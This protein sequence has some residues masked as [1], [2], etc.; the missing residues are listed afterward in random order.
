MATGTLHPVLNQIRR[1]VLGRDGAGQ[2][3]GQLLES[4]ISHRDEAA[5]EVLVH[6]H[7]PM[8]LGVCRR[9]LRHHHDAEDAFQ[10][11]FLVLVRKAAWIVPRDMVANWL[12]GVACRTALKARA[13][14]ARRRAHEKQVMEMPEAEAVEPDECWRDLHPLLDQ[15]LS[16]LPD[17]YRL[18]VVL[19]HL[20]GKTGREA[21]RLLGWPEG[22]V[23][24]R[25]ARARALLARRLA[26][27]GLTASA[28][29]ATLL[30]KASASAGVPPALVA[31]TIQAVSL[32]AAGKAA[33]GAALAERVVQAMI[34]SKIKRVTAI[35]LAVVV[36]IGA[37]G[38]LRHALAANSATA[39][40][41]NP[42][43]R[44][45][46][47]ASQKP[48]LQVPLRDRTMMTVALSG[49][50]KLL[51]VA[52]HDKT[53]VQLWDVATGK[54]HTLAGNP[55]SVTALAFSPDGKTL[56]TGTG[57]WL[58]DGAPGEIKLWDVGTGKERAT[59]GRLPQMV[60]VLAFAPDGKALASA[61]KTLKLWDVAS[62][63]ETSEFKLGPQEGHCWPVAWAP[64]GKGLAMGV[65]MLEDNTPGAVALY[66]VGAGKV[67][68][69]L[70]GHK[71]AVACVAFAPDGKTMAS[72][73]SRGTLKLWDVAAAK[74]RATIRNAGSIFGTFFL[75]SLAFTADGKAVVATMMLG[76]PEPGPVLREW[77]VADGKERTTYRGTAKGFPI[78]LSGDATVVGLASPKLGEG[79]V[80]PCGKLELWERRSLAAAVTR[81]R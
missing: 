11:T 61:S 50:G 10:A 64:D 45:A 26:R 23:S 34:H 46:D 52:P 75:Q 66:D 14:I 70:P 58:P 5:F 35:V 32:L 63:K 38:L 55:F 24:S 73:D 65:G 37:G 81:E 13:M 12:Y 43:Q 15:Q 31:S 16:R 2:T 1:S 47:P 57:S 56:A 78:A 4:F 54:E 60:V 79:L 39:V 74:E 40:A 68:A 44:P 42:R 18:P 51:A 72:A 69:T 71:G 7:G 9:V 25:L 49:N 62:G 3:D 30:V 67:R 29:L 27:H 80:G 21:A 41:D 28:A 22:T 48:L 17:K 8:V 19:C 36:G 20:E 33:T 59:L 76:A 6:R 77:N 53:T